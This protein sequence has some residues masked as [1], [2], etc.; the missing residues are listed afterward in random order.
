VIN[1]FELRGSEHDLNQGVLEHFFRA[2]AVFQDSKGMGYE[3]TAMLRVE[4][5]KLLDGPHFQT[6]GG[7]FLA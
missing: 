6:C 7:R 3:F 2:S 5:T 4:G 1:G